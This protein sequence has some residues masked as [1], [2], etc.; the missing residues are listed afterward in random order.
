MSKCQSKQPQCSKIGT[1]EHLTM[2]SVFPNVNL[3]NK[4]KKNFFKSYVGFR[5]KHLSLTST[6]YRAVT[7]YRH[8]LML[9]G[10][11]LL[12]LPLHQCDR[13]RWINYSEKLEVS[14][15]WFQFIQPVLILKASNTVVLTLYDPT[16]C[17]MVLISS[18]YLTRQQMLW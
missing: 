3:M 7:I 16:R 14:S 4:E 9:T 2:F 13:L 6:A 8:F 11:F 1:S 17:V 15:Q 12:L 10:L 5:K 18:Q